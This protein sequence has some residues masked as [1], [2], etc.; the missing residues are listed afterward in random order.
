VTVA[1]RALY[2]A[3]WTVKALM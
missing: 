3:M 1:K 2:V